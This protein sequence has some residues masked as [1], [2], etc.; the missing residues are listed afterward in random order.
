MFRFTIRDVLWL[1]VVVAFAICWFRND[2]TSLETIEELEKKNAR[3][4]YENSAY[5]SRERALRIH[6]DSWERALTSS[7]ISPAD[8]DT[9]AQAKSELTSKALNEAYQSESKVPSQ[10]QP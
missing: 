4:D 7:G 1:M 3:L 10:R 6:A 5:K 9:I 8:K 2:W